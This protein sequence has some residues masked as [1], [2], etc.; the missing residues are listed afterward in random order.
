M[1]EASN[2]DPVTRQNYKDH[3]LQGFTKTNLRS[4]VLRQT[5]NYL[6]RGLWV[7]IYNDTTGELIAGP[8]DPDQPR[9]K[10]II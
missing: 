6:K 3:P 7:E 2:L 10:Y 9:P 1:V 4:L 8:F 5:E